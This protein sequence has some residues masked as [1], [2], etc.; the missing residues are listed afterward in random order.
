MHPSE[1]DGDNGVRGSAGKDEHGQGIGP[2]DRGS[3]GMTAVHWCAPDIPRDILDAAW[4]PEL[5]P[6]T[7]IHVRP[8]LH[9]RMTSA[10]PAPRAED[11]PVRPELDVPLVVDDQIPLFPGYEIH[12]CA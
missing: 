9:A 4:S 8:E 1:P 5:P 2:T 3:P 10:V 7:S 11:E 12:R 6:P